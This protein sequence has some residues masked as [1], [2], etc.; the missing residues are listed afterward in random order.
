ME[1]WKNCKIQQNI[2]I[3]S[4]MGN[5]SS[6]PKDLL[7]VLNEKKLFLEI[8]FNPYYTIPGTTLV[9]LCCRRK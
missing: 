3:T 7:Q 4:Y 1:K 2:S 8:H 5:I 6:F 9:Q